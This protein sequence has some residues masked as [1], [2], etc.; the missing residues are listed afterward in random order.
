S[1]EEIEELVLKLA[2]EGN[3]PA[4]IGLVL[5]DQYG[6]P[7]V[8]ALTGTKITKILSAKDMG[9]S[10]PEDLQS[11]INKA[12]LLDNHLQ[13]HINDRHNK[14]ALMLVES[15]IRRLTKYYIG[16]GKLPKD[17]RYDMEKARL[18]VSK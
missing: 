12:V 3:A 15:K 2:K 16:S 6:I 18:L 5:R 11:L 9:L 4:K 7:D 13:K 17:W 1:K 10:V 8:K 14:R